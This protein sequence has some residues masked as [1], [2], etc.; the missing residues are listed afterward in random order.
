MEGA[1]VQQYR[2]RLRIVSDVLLVAL[3][4]GDQGGASPSHL[5]RRGN[6]SYKGLEELLSQLL[7][8]GLLLEKQESK[9]VKYVLSARG[10]EYLAQ[11]RQFESFAESYGLRL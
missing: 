10:S 6:L 3:N 5:M 9:G 4:S 8:A 11:Y 7:S 1:R 2:S